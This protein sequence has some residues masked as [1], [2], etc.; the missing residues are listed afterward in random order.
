MFGELSKK[1][2]EVWKAM[3]EKDK[4]VMFSDLLLIKIHQRVTN[5][6][7]CYIYIFARSL[8]VW[9]QKAQY[10]QHKQNKAEA[11]TV[12]NKSLTET[13]SKGL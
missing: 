2:A 8:Q 7:V 4:L 13:K 1:L 10:L 6:A 11:T 5:F 12:K 3:P 9:R